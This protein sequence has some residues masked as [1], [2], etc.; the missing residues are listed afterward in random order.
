VEVGLRDEAARRITRRVGGAHLREEKGY[1][2]RTL[3]NIKEVHEDLYR[4]YERKKRRGVFSERRT[5]SLHTGG[6]GD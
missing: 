5:D 3:V 2:S 1:T 6:D 4:T